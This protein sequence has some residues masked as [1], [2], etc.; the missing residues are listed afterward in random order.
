MQFSGLDLAISAR[1]PDLAA[2]S[3]LAGTGLPALH[4]LAFDGHLTDAAGG[5]QTGLALKA[6]KLS[7]PTGDLG[8]DITLAFQP[9]LSVQGQLAGKRLDLDAMQAAVAAAPSIH[10]AV[11]NDTPQPTTSAPAPAPPVAAPPA[12]APTGPKRLISDRRFNLTALGRADAD[13]QLT[14]AEIRSGG[15]SYRDV[16]L[17]LLLDH[18]K[19]SLEPFT[20]TLPG[21]HLDVHLTYDTGTGAAPLTFSI[22]APGVA[23]KPLL[24]ALELPDDV[25]GIVELDADVTANGQ[26]PHALAGS[27]TGRIGVIMTDGLLDNRLLSGLL[28][29]TAKL[30]RMPAD[31]VISGGQTKLRCGA[32]RLDANNGGAAVN[33]FVLDTARALIQGG[34]S[35][36]FRDETVAMRL[37]PLLRIGGPGL[38]VPVKVTGRLESPDV[39]VDSGGAIESVA[40]SVFSTVTGVPGTIAGIARNPL[41]TLTNALAGERGGDACGPAIA[42][43]RGA[44]PAAK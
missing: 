10:P 24:T 23:L 14:M 43:A 21:G 6:L 17:H 40:G 35:I 18:G 39:A 37:R 5:L 31:L 20:A 4:D 30:A 26:S 1:V 16:A 15:A 44:R 34:G 13:M 3:P 36:N 22:A 19:L 9:R 38:V 7:G 25:T 2:L 27:L 8:G 41:G 11:A 32:I 28:N 33:A 42:A 12:P 29:G